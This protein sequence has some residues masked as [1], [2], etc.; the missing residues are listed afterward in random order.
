LVSGMSWAHGLLID[1]NLA[2]PGRAPVS[3]SLWIYSR[4][5][6]IGSSKKGKKNRDGEGSP[7]TRLRESADGGGGGRAATAALRSSLLLGG[8][9]CRMLQCSAPRA[10]IHGGRSSAHSPGRRSPVTRRDAR[11]CAGDAGRDARAARRKATPT[12]VAAREEWDVHSRGS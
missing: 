9:P 10:G 6:A 3:L 2:S 7:G 5:R 1:S 8:R 4:R 12:V 11:A